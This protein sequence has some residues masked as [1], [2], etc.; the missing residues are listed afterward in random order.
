MGDSQTV[1]SGADATLVGTPVNSTYSIACLDEGRLAL[2]RHP[3]DGRVVAFD[4]RDDAFAFAVSLE[5]AGHQS[6]GT[7]QAPAGEP[8][9]MVSVPAAEVELL[10]PTE[11][12][13]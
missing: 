11:L 12:A 4:D 2:L 5:L 3:A 6:A 10:A 13:A 9:H 1:Q 7:V 8:L